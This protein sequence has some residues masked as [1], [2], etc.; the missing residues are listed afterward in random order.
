MGTLFERR[1][2]GDPHPSHALGEA[3]KAATAIDKL[4]VDS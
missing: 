3:H 4:G 1:L 2:G